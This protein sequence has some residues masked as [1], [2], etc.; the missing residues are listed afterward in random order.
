MQESNLKLISFTISIIGVI[1]L[2]LFSIF[3]GLNFDSIENINSFD[4]DAKVLV[5]STIVEIN[6]YANMTFITLEDHKT[7]DAVL[8]HDNFP[9]KFNSIMDLKPGDKII[10]G[11]TKSTYNNK[12]NIIINRI[13]KS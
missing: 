11:G 7:I 4:D 2:Y 1:F 6:E 12:S 9:S 8:F 13:I 5:E 10:I 3:S